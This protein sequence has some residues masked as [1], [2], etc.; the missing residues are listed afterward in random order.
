FKGLS[1]F[2][3]EVASAVCDGFACA[4]RLSGAHIVKFL[5]RILN[6]TP[7]RYFVTVFIES[8]REVLQNDAW[9]GP[10]YICTAAFVAVCSTCGARVDCLARFFTEDVIDVRTRVRC[11]TVIFIDA[12]IGTRD[13]QD[14]GV[15]GDFAVSAFADTFACVVT[16]VAVCAVRFFDTLGQ[17]HTR[18]IAFFISN[19]ACVSEPYAVEYEFAVFYIL[20]SL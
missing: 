5:F 4:I 12:T 10:I 15:T 13:D 14:F 18:I 7:A 2:Y 11:T 6:S 3:E 17:A 20:S 9:V 16:G 8:D 1:K 19:N